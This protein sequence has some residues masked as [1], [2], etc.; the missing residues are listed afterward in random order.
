MAGR[1]DI[2]KDGKGFDVNPEN[3]NRKGRPRKLV[4]I[5]NKQLKEDGYGLVTK[6]QIIDAYQ[7]LINLPLSE[8]RKISTDKT[9]AYPILFVLVAKGLLDN[10]GSEYLEKLLDRIIGRPTQSVEIDNKDKHNDIDFSD[11]TD[12]ELKVLTRIGLKKEIK[13]NAFQRN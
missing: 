7:T 5:I 2:Y 1:K 3:I 10:K 11:V 9:D 12:E 4:A 6:T 13:L 8:I